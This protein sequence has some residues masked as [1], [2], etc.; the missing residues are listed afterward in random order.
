M[1]RR[2]LLIPV[3][4]SVAAMLLASCATTDRSMTLQPAYEG[5]MVNDVRYMAAV[6]TMAAGRGVDVQWINP[7][8]VRKPSGD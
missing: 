2:A 4:A 7:P 1:N 5:Q 3:T 8:K 6:E